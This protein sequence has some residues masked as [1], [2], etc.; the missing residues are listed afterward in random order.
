[1][2]RDTILMITSSRLFGIELRSR[3]PLD[4]KYLLL[5]ARTFYGVNDGDFY[6]CH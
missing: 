6:H 2:K 3:A 1:M 4:S 5:Q